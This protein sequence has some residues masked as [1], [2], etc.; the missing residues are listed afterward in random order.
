MVA[1]IFASNIKSIACCFSSRLENRN[2]LS[3][4]EKAQLTDLR[5]SG[6]KTPVAASLMAVA[7]ETQKR[8]WNK[9]GDTKR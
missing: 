5:S 1:H 7:M 3:V 4:N 2:N 6:I 8:K 9:S